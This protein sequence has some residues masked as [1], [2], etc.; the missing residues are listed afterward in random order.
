MAR[1]RFKLE[2]II[3]MLREVEVL[4]ADNGGSRPDYL[5]IEKFDPAGALRRDV[6]IMG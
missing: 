1:Q 5:A 6:L 2:Q 4:V 3:A